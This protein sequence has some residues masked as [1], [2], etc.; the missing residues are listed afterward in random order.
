MNSEGGTLRD[1]GGEEKG[2]TIPIHSAHLYV[3][4][5]FS[6]VHLCAILWT[7]ARQAPLSM[8]FSRL[9]YWMN[10]FVKM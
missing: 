2:L 5:C 1:E 10:S 8:G 3:L 9:E 7:V 4:S 6:H